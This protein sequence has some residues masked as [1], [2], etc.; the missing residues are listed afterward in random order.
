MK[1]HDLIIIG[2][3]P[4]GISAG[5]YGKNFGLECLIIGEEKGGL[6]NAAYKV[7]NYPGIFGVSGKELSKKF[8]AHQKHLKI[9]FKNG[10][11]EGIVRQKNEF[12]I[13]TNKDS[14]QARTLIL[15]FGTQF[16]KLTIKNIE[17]FEG[18]G[19]SYRV[20]DRAFLFKNRMVAVI[21][22]ANAAAM[23]AV[24]ISEKAKKVYIIYRRE[25]LRA[26]AIWINRI[27]KI[28]NIQVIYNSN[29][30][31]LKGKDGLEKIV[32]QDKK[33][34]E[35]SSLLVETGCVPNTYLIHELG[36][37]VDENGYIRTE[38]DQSTN[39]DGIFAAGD[40]TTGSNEF[41]QIITACAEGAI[42]ALGALNYISKKK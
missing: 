6:I 25:K 23:S 41:R 42:A 4:A 11:V 3:G 37:A 36:I 29:I 14:H 30:V 24:M 13:L 8:I 15:A 34:L 40:I 26:D 27:N 7:E 33:E 18:K 1:T 17:K 32:L 2:A 28:K 39:I 22:G 21:G 38:K 31:A 9:P 12:K 16:R 5:I 35:V 20:D 19:V 10:L